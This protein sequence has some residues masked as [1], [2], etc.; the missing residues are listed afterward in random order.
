MIGQGDEIWPTVTKKNSFAI[1]ECR[2]DLSR[3]TC[4]ELNATVLLS[5]FDSVRKEN[6]YIKINIQN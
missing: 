3:Y 5:N 4:F 2:I 6:I 1:K